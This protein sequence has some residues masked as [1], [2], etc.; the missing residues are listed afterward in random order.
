MDYLATM[1]DLQAII[2]GTGCL[3]LGFAYGRHRRSN[4]RPK[5]AGLLEKSNGVC[6]RSIIVQ[7]FPQQKHAMTSTLPTPRMRTVAFQNDR[8]QYEE[9]SPDEQDIASHKRCTKR[10][11]TEVV[12]L[13]DRHSSDMAELLGTVVEEVLGSPQQRSTVPSMEKDQKQK[14]CKVDMKKLGD[15][16]DLSRD[17]GEPWSHRSLNQGFKCINLVSSE[18]EEFDEQQASWKINRCERF[19]VLSPRKVVEVGSVE[20]ESKCLGALATPIL[21]NECSVQDVEFP[22][23]DC[24]GYTGGSTEGT[25]DS[26]SECEVDTERET[27][28]MGILLLSED[29][30]DSEAPLKQA[31]V[32]CEKKAETER[33]LLDTEMITASSEV[34]LKQTPVSC[35]KKAETEGNLMDTA[36]MAASSEA[37]LKETHDPP[38]DMEKMMQCERSQPRCS[39]QSEV[40]DQN[41]QSETPFCDLPIESVQEAQGTTSPSGWRQPTIL[42]ANDTGCRLSFLDAK[43]LVLPSFSDK[44]YCTIR[45]KSVPRF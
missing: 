26:N 9:S 38:P 24:S 21:A 23:L 41:F 37:P 32:S 33:N 13:L 5:L 27:L 25:T 43:S 18:N 8:S 17:E 2:V 12:D 28:A 7:P 30:A 34:P 36:V 15:L 22:Q 44:K 6:S 16:E 1:V 14:S 11:L 19:M 29:S 42:S 20:K 40:T 10:H 31:P 39:P 4:N 35:E 45:V 3:A